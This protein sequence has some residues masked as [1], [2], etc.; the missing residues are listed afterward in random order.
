MAFWYLEGLILFGLVLAVLRTLMYR[1]VKLPPGPK[2]WPIFGNSLDAPKRYEWKTYQRWSQQ[3]GTL[4]FT[5]IWQS[6]IK[7]V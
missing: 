2:G 5:E 4:N 1:C 7:A 6:L 3:Y